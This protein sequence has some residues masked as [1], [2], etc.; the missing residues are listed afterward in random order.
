MFDYEKYGYIKDKDKSKITRVLKDKIEL[1][2][3]SIDAYLADPYMLI[4]RSAED[5]LTADIEDERVIVKRNG[6]DNTN[7]M[8]LP[9]RS[10]DNVYFKFTDDSKCRM[11]F[12]IKNICYSVMADV[13]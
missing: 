4:L 2:T 10:V 12:T 5:S 11:F 8:N 1:E 3:V 6:K 7:I 13:C 9:I